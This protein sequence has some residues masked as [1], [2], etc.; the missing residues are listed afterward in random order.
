MID[1]IRIYKDYWIEVFSHEDGTYTALIELPDES[2]CVS[3]TPR[4]SFE[5]AILAAEAWSDTH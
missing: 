5:A 3:T 2:E 4:P 1:N